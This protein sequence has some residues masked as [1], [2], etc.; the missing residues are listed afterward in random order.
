MRWLIHQ[1]F[2]YDKRNSLFSVLRKTEFFSVR[3]LDGW[4]LYQDWSL[5]ARDHQG[6]KGPTAAR[7]RVDPSRGD[8]EDVGM[9]L[10]GLTH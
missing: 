3:P 1:A 9:L 6:E 7:R 8:Q 4:S 5:Q 10:P 2:S